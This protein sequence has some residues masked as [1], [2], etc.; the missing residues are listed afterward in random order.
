MGWRAG[1]EPSP[2]PGH[3][4]TLGWHPGHSAPRQP[5]QLCP[6]PTLL[7]L[8]QDVGMHGPEPGAAEESPA[9]GEAE[10]VGVPGMGWDGIGTGWG[11]KCWDGGS[12]AVFVP[13]SLLEQLKKL[14][15]LVVQSSNK[16]AQTGTC[17]A[18]RGASRPWELWR[19]AGREG[20]TDALLVLP[21]AVSQLLVPLPCCAQ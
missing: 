8:S 11:G 4:D 15:A 19:W 3:G 13:R 16:A 2:S 17:L 18:V 7:S 5:P 12:W 9:P 6:D 21:P 10:L 20:G 1:T 14:Q